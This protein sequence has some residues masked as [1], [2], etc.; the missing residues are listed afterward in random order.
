MLF[1]MTIPASV[2]RKKAQSISKYSIASSPLKDEQ[3]T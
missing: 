3:L 1:D 2:Y